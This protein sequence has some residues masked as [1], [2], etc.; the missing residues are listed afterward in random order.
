MM[1]AAFLK[2]YQNSESSHSGN[3]LRRMFWSGA[4]AYWGV[5]VVSQRRLAT[6]RDMLMRCWSLSTWARAGACFF[7]IMLYG[8][9]WEC[10][11][12]DLFTKLF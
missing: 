2:F 7:Y 6:E 5:G 3:K 4:A 1:G 8:S 10:L 11:V 12:F 9:S